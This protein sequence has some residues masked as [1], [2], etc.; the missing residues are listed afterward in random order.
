MS[1]HVFFDAGSVVWNVR[2]TEKYDAIREIIHRSPVLRSIPSLDLDHFTEIVVGRE[3]VQ[4]TG[5]GH[6]VAVAHGRSPA[7]RDSEVTLGVSKQ[8]IDYD[9]LDG[10]PVH[11]LFI[12][13]NHPDKQM[14]Y[15]TILSSLVSLL[16]QE[17][18]RRELLACICQEE[19]EQK[20]CTAFRRVI[21]Q[22]TIA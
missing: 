7:I 12:V 17:P 5:F 20:L 1:Q 8:G 3:K 14:D 2:S 10:R 19:V 9:A 21:R 18:F 16:R 6:G 11:L 13:A 4:T 15:L 22:R